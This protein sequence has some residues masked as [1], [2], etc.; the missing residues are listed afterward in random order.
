M[1]KWFP[2]LI[3]PLVAGCA[4]MQTAKTTE[5][6]EV[7]TADLARADGSWAG[8]VTISKRSDGTFLSLAGEA[9]AAG[10]FGMHIHA[11]G[12]CEGPAF[13]SAGAHWNPADKQHGFENPMGSHGGDLPNVVA[14]AD[15]KIALEY[16][17]SD[18]TLEGADGIIDADGAAFVIHEKADD[19]RTDPSGDSGKRIICGVLKSGNR[20]R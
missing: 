1:H 16:K 10:T 2:I 17:M 11:V 13:T 12:K 9:P 19:Y 14:G 6:S 5:V 3:L 15:R 18:F 4:S 20:A 7:I 8:V